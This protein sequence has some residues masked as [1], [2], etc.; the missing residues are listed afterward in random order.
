MTRIP[1]APP[2]EEL[3]GELWSEWLEQ[4]RAIV[5]DRPPNHYTSS[6]R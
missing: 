3:N 1:E 6:Y 5:E 2:Q 4:C